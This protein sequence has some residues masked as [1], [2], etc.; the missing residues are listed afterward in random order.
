MFRKPV[1]ILVRVFFFYLGSISA[2]RSR[3]PPMAD[4]L[5]SGRAAI[6]NG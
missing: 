6:I 3:Y 5:H 2:L 4:E 1:S